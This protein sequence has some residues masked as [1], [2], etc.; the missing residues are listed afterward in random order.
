MLD[1]Q[2]P[3]QF[4]L[5]QK[6]RIKELDRS[7]IINGIFIGLNGIEYRVRYFDNCDS[8]EVYFYDFELE[9]VK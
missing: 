1:E 7:G 2:Y 9:D 6:V 5:K 3:I 8:K 4:F